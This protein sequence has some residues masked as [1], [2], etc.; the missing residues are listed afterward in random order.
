MSLR[1]I[2]FKFWL[3]I[4]KSAN[5]GLFIDVGIPA[6][7]R[8]NSDFSKDRTHLINESKASLFQFYLVGVR[9]TAT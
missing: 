2:L 4:A 1:P 8:Q 3:G 9:R 6:A 5:Q 7:N